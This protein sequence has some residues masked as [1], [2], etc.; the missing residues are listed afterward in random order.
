MM[1]STTIHDRTAQ[2]TVYMTD[3]GTDSEAD[4]QRN[5]PVKSI[6]RQPK[7][8]AATETALLNKPAPMKDLIGLQPPLNPDRSLSNAAARGNPNLRQNVLDAITVD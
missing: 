6:L 4:R 8:T 3:V 1:S 5:P 2:M 7:G